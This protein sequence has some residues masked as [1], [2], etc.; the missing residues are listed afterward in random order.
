MTSPGLTP[1]GQETVQSPHWWQVHTYG[2]AMS[3]SRIPQAAMIICLRG[4]TSWSAD[5]EQDAVQAPHCM[6]VVSCEPLAACSFSMNAISGLTS[7]IYISLKGL[8][9]MDSIVSR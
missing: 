4:K 7:I 2:S 1:R 9:P 5:K 3:R 8:G 6:Q